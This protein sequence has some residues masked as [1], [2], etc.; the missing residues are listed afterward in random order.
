MLPPIET[1]GHPYNSSATCDA[2][3]GSRDLCKLSLDLRMSDS[4]L[5][6]Y[7]REMICRKTLSRSRDSLSHIAQCISPAHCRVLLVQLRPYV[8]LSYESMFLYFIRAYVTSPKRTL[9]SKN[10]NTIVKSQVQLR[11]HFCAMINY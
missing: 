10:N 3:G 6:P 5:C 9:S 7:N 4:C 1:A 11:R 8:L 2:R